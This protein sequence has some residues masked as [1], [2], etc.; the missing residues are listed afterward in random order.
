MLAWCAKPPS[1]ASF[2]GLGEEPLQIVVEGRDGVDEPAMEN[3]QLN[4]FDSDLDG[5]GK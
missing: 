4:S 3:L 2:A 5:V 1:Y